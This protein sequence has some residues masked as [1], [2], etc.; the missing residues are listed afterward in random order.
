MGDSGCYVLSTGKGPAMY[1]RN[2]AAMWASLAPWSRPLPGPA[3]VATIEVPAQPAIRVI[4]RSPLAEDPAGHIGAVFAQA[5]EGSRVTVEDSFGKLR[6]PVA[7]GMTVYHQPIMVRPVAPVPRPPSRDGTTVRL[8][9]SE[10]ALVQAE[11]VIVEGFPRRALQPFQ[12]GRMLPALTIATPG[13]QVW[14]GYAGGEPAAVCCSY[15]DGAAVGIYW[16][17]T[18]PAFR[19]RGLGRA[20]MTAALAARPD[21]PATLV[22]TAAGEPLYASLGFRTVCQ[23]VWYRTP[24]LS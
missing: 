11:R 3:E 16:L 13:W 21:R 20:L 2:A 4:L 14:L 23:A 1:A 22:A 6:L 7:D 8:A 15:D 12:P 24:V 9:D 17:A 19:S 18:M 5:P 10:A